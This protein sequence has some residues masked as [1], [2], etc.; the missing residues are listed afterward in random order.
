MSLL[1]QIAERALNRPLMIHPDKLPMILGVLEGRIPLGDISALKAEAIERVKELPE[2]AQATIFGPNPTA[3]RFVGSATDEDPISGRRSALP[4]K[5]TREGVAVIPILGSL[6]NRGAWLGSYSGETSYEGIKFQ[7]AHAAD[8][9]RTNAILLDIDSPGGEAV[10]CFEVAAAIR[11]ASTKKPVTA[12]VNGMAAS[13]AY[14]IAAGANR[15]VTTETGVVG[16]IGVVMLHADFSRK[17]DKEGIT[18]TL[19]FAGAHK[20]DGHP[21]APLDEQ[22]GVADDLQNEVDQFYSLFVRSVA[23]GR[24]RMTEKQIRGT[25]AR[26]YI[27]ADAVEKGLA[28][29]VGTFETALADLSM[30]KVGLSSSKRR[31]TMSTSKTAPDANSGLTNAE[32][33]TKLTTARTEGHA[34]GKAEGKAEAETA[35]KQSIDAAVAT[36][37]TEATKAETDRIRA[38]T[39]LEECK[40][41]EAAALNLA[42]NSTMTAEQ[43]KPVI[44]AMP[45]SAVG[46]RAADNPIGL[47]LDKPGQQQ[48]SAAYSPDEVAAVIN[49]PA[50]K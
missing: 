2:G 40:G 6:I 37:R 31:L 14:A 24:D 32:V 42:L 3:S 1:M 27:G 8:D 7:I 5:R 25:E 44:A 43:A 23:A 18:P 10:G 26:T 49:K 20:V 15:I 36:A 38:I 16:S 19:I 30:A 39:S 9:Q 11:S 29:E 12:V 33:E 47:A 48:S 50:R 22:E 28:D 34:A 45:K 4:Y 13:A 41:R 35:G 17:L 46:G 21:F